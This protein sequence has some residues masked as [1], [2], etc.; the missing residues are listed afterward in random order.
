MFVRLIVGF[1][2]IAVMSVANAA[3]VPKGF[4]RDIRMVDTELCEK[5]EIIATALAID[6]MQS[7]VGARDLSQ[8]VVTA[9]LNNESKD[10]TSWATFHFISVYSPT[11]HG[12]LYSKTYRL[13]WLNLKG[14]LSQYP[15]FIGGAAYL[16]C[17]K[18]IGTKFEYL[19]PIVGR[20]L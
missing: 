13:S 16:D 14:N 15:D 4:M 12:N 6:N 18:A 7:S 3:P 17:K 9:L 10:P 8:Q 11:L 20:A 19:R 2:M 5:V 1:V